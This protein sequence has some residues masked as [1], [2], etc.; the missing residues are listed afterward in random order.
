MMNE[1]LEDIAQLSK[2]ISNC[3]GVAQEMAETMQNNLQ[4]KL[5]VLKSQTEE[6]AIGFGT[7][8]MP[9]AQ[10]LVGMASSA[11]QKFSGLNDG[12]KKFIVYAGLAAAAAG[13]LASV[14]G[15]VTTGIGS[16]ISTLGGA[17]T[18]FSSAGGGAAGLGAAITSIIGPAGWVVLGLTAVTAA[19][20]ALYAATRDANKGARELGDAMKGVAD[21]AQDFS[22]GIHTA[23]GNTS[24]FASTLNAG[25]S[26]SDVE[27]KISKVQKKI[28]A[29]TSKASEERRELTQKEIKKLKEYFDELQKL[30]EQKFEYYSNNLNALQTMA[31]SGLEM[32]AETAKSVLADAQSFRKEAMDEALNAYR[33]ELANL[34]KMYGAESDAY[35]KGAEKAAETY[36]QR[37]ESI[38][39]SYAAITGTIADAYTEQTVQDSAFYTKLQ[40]H[41]A[42]IESENQR[43]SEK[44][45]EIQEIA[46]SV[47]MQAANQNKAE[48]ERHMAAMDEIYQQMADDLD[49]TAQREIGTWLALVA[50]TEASGGE[51]SNDV[52]QM[53][54]DI[55]AVLDTLPDDAKE[56]MKN[57]WLGMKKELEAAYPELYAAAEDDANSIINAVDKALGI[58]S[59]SRVMMEKGRYTIEGMIQGMASKK[60]SATSSINGIMQSMVTAAGSVSFTGIGGN[61]VSGILSGLNDK[62]P[63]LMNRARSLAT[64]IAGVIGGALRINSPSKVM[65]PMGQAVAEGMEVGLLNGAGSLYETA[66]AISLETAEALGGIS[67]RGLNYASVHSMNYGDRLDRLLDAVERLADSQTTMEID[68]RPFGRLVREYV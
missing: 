51:I 28:T 44:L 40:Q 22:S 65:I 16:M 64:G 19:G 30:T 59:P 47:P 31:E 60:G 61:V 32:T 12:T 50:E 53:S 35:K 63:S 20:I 26:L 18:A 37:V 55:C 58:A 25:F 33:D 6:L 1:G 3:D 13:P 2:A 14:L 43:H 42:D 66:S 23:T 7:E 45:A 48:M 54:I 41:N 5:T 11:V 36:N 24:E 46:L 56:S 38:K 9:V 67:S 4:G 34:E 10:D 49:S 57:T 15:N 21:Y 39:N 62:A 29:I 8:L 52:R 27:D 17:A 68:G